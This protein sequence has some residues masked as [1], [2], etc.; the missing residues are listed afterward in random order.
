MESGERPHLVVLQHGIDGRDS[1]FSA[2]RHELS[3]HPDD[4][5][6]WDTKCNHG[7]THEGIEACTERLWRDLEARLMQLGGRRLR[8]SLVGHSFGGLLLRHCATRLHA[9]AL[10]TGTIELHCYIS[11]ATPHLGSRSLGGSV[12]AGARALYGLSGRELLIDA[13]ASCALDVRLCDEEHIHALSAFHRRITYSSVEGDWVV[14]F[15]S[16]SL[17]D[18]DE[19]AE[20]VPPPKTPKPSCSRS[21]G[22]CR[23]AMASCHQC[24]SMACD[25]WHGCRHAELETAELETADLETRPKERGS[26]DEEGGL[27]SSTCAE[28]L[29]GVWDPQPTIRQHGTWDDELTRE[30][31]GHRIAEMLRRLRSSGPWEVHAV[32]HARHQDIIAIPGQRYERDAGLTVV[33]HLAT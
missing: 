1:D 18:A 19:Q 31:R 9:F 20:L 33:R 11:L 28:P 29:P 4:L 24:G 27:L 25:T 23:S 16:G 7:R 5:E 21:V 12:R 8:V 14:S 26:A 2:L 32:H 30:A 13:D 17:L 22:C 15:A 3:L 6:V 10:Q